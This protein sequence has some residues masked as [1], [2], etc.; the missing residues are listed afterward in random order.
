MSVGIASLVLI[1]SILVAAPAALAYYPPPFHIIHGEEAAAS[2]PDSA[3]VDPFQQYLESLSFESDDS[4]SDQSLEMISVSDAEIDSLAKVFDETGELPDITLSPPERRWRI[5]PGLAGVRYNRVEGLNIQPSLTLRIPTQRRLEVSS[6]VG[7][8]TASEEATWQTGI[9]ATL[10]RGNLAPR[11]KVDYSRDLDRYG[12]GGMWGNSITALIVGEDYDD[13]FLEEGWAV[14]LRTTPRPYEIE[15]EYRKVEQDS[16]TNETDFNF[17]GGDDAFRLNP[18]IDPGE[19]RLFEFEI[20]IKDLPAGI[21]S[22]S[23]RTI[24]AGNGLGG[25]FDY[26]SWRGEVTAAQ[27]SFFGDLLVLELEGGLVTGEPT[28]QSLHHLGGVKTLRGYEVNEIPAR[29]YAHLSLDYEIGTN[30]LRPLPL[31]G[32]LKIQAIPFFDCAAVFETQA[33]DGTVI[34]M[35][36]PYYRSAAGLG[37][38]KNF[39]GIPGRTGQLRLDIMRRLDRGDDNTSFRAMITV[40]SW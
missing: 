5:T 35:D 8:G 3:S 12:S 10:T 37:L 23:V 30:V 13:Y 7:Y 25:D 19:V 26:E 2:R 28:F 21:K 38:Q 6:H 1:G 9:R 34:E 4:F 32:R 39:L 18:A 11:I 17:F 36:D 24:L 20:G 22:A 27:K 16:L 40:V 14:G 15:L 31:L 29:Q 33:R